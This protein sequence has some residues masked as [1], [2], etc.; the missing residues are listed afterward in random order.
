MTFFAA[1]DAVAE[2]AE[3]QYCLWN[4]LLGVSPGH[5]FMIK[6]VERLVNLILNRADLL[7]LEK[8]V[9]RS[10]GKDETETW[11]I[12]AVPELLLSGPCGLGISV[13]EVLGNNPLARYDL[14]WMPISQRRP[15]DLGDVLILVV[16]QSLYLTALV[17]LI[18]NPKCTYQNVRLYFMYSKIS[19]TWE[20]CAS[21]T[22]SEP[23]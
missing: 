23:F 1:R 17:I 21:Q 13:N 22:S 12:R 8:D 9:C 20:L 19:K 11:K 4:G 14:G 7:D 16:S 15:I 10:S 2:Y 18:A 6:T 3:G 5:P